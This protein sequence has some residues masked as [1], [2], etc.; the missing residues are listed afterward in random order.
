M[1]GDL[2]GFVAATF[3][4]GV[5]FVQAPTTLLAMVDASIGGKT[6]VNHPKAK[7]FIGSFYQPRLV[8]ADVQT[9]A[10]LPARELTSGWAEV[11]KH[12]F[13]LDAEG[14]SLLEDQAEDLMR[15]KPEV[16]TAAIRRSAAVK[17]R[18]VSEDEK[19]RG[20][21]TLLNYGHTIAH[22]LETATDYE[23]FLHGEAVAMGMAGAA[24]IGQKLGILSAKDAKRHRALLEKFGLPTQCAGV[25]ARAVLKAMEFDKK[26]RAKA[27]R[28]VLLA[29]LGQAIIRSDV[30]QAV[31][32][33]VV[34]QLVGG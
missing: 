8:A 9:L 22:G 23:R 18:I 6:A 28:W 15:L 12:A 17:A 7:N 2:A 33:E 26:V 16:V 25:D 29:S 27:I 3:L 34:G 20:R 5:P 1:V 31:V 11:I 10:T 13:I 21:R 30:P 19:E 14:V 4:R 32:R 24:S